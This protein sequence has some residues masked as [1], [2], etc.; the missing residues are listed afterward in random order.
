MSGT[1]VAGAAWLGDPSLQKLLAVLSEGND[2]AR[3]VG[4]AVRNTLLGEAVTDI[5][6]ATMTKD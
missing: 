3:V 2:S 6:I 1:S 4:G 5:D